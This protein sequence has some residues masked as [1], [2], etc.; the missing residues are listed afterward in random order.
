MAVASYEGE[1]E[2]KQELAALAKRRLSAS[3]IASITKIALKQ[4]KVRTPTRQPTA[5][6]IL[7]E[8]H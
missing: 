7:A 8:C 3:R 5:M 2:L 1:E 6:T 4:V